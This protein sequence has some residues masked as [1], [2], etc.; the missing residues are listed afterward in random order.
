VF[1]AVAL[2]HVSSQYQIFFLRAQN[3]YYVPYIVSYLFEPHHDHAVQKQKEWQFLV[4]FI[5]K[6]LGA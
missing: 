2:Q 6:K 5:S 4:K 1:R 3:N